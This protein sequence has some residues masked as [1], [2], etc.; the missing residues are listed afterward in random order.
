MPRS[1]IY[2]GAL[3]LI[4]TCSCLCAPANG[5]AAVPCGQ[6]DTTSQEFTACAETTPEPGPVNVPANVPNNPQVFCTETFVGNEDRPADYPADRLWIP[7]ISYYN[8]T[9]ITGG[10]PSAAVTT[11][12]SKTGLGMVRIG[13]GAPPPPSP[14]QIAQTVIA[15]LP[16]PTPSPNF[17]PEADR[18]SVQL[19]VWLWI[20]NSVP[21]T[22]S[23]TLAGITVTVSAA[24]S[25]TTWNMGEPISPDNQ[26]QLKPPTVCAGPGTKL[27]VGLDVLQPPCGYTYTWQSLP[28][29]TNNT[30]QWPVEVT[31]TWAITWTASTGAAGVDT[32]T[33]TTQTALTVASYNSILVPDGPR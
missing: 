27:A 2:I 19:P 29:R 14:E 25:T 13:P 18:I 8:Q 9:C 10:D 31:A 11:T 26:Y 17:A 20:E 28:E 24:L 3:C 16:I 21:V 23:E 4:I 22:A 12:I 33:T 15:K 7:L 1:L 30:G 32:V 6:F 5:L